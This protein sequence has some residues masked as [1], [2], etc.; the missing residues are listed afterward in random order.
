MK[1]KEKIILWV[2][3]LI[4]LLPT[5][6]I[7]I[8]SLIHENN[9]SLYQYTE[10]FINNYPFFRFFTNSI[11]YSALSA[12]IC[13]VISLPVAYLF[14]KIRFKLR[15]GLFF[16]YI[17]VMMLP[18]QATMLPQYI[19]LR[20]LNLLNTPIALMLWLVFS[21]TAVFLLRQFIKAI[22]DE[23]I[24][25]AKLETNS[26]VVILLRI[27]LPQIKPAI[28]TLM[29]LTFCESWNMY[30]QALTFASQN[31][32]IMPLSCVMEYLSDD[33]AFSG[34]TVYMLP[35]IMLFLIFEKS[36]YSGMEK[37]KW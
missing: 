29:I 5:V 10:L 34:A 23:I 33:I 3:T 12:I 26:A 2:I 22:P 6:A 36:I 30:E 9:L 1:L 28:I 11:V 37:Y 8:K 17:L 31:I 25:S 4:Y 32:E 27:V 21:P 7:I 13:I 19:L 18:F 16:I 35:I 14:A 20:D 15:D 24:D